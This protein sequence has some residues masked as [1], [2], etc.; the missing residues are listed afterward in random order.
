MKIIKNILKLIPFLIITLINIGLLMDDMKI[1]LIC[2][3]LW[4]V[5]L[6]IPVILSMI[7]FIGSIHCSNAWERTIVIW[8]ILNTVLFAWCLFADNTDKNCT[9]NTMAIHY[10]TYYTN[11]KDL[12]NYV[13][14]AIDD[15][16]SIDLEFDGRS[17]GIFH[18][19][20]AS[21]VYKNHWDEEAE[22][23]KD[24]LMTIVGLSEEEY[25]N[26]RKQLKD[27]DCLGI[28]FSQLSS[29]RMTIYFCREGMGLYSYNIYSRP[30]TEKEK[31]NAIED[32]ALIPYNEYCIFEYGGG[33]IGPQIFA[34]KEREEFMKRNNNM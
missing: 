31:C 21:G 14:T 17:A 15:S 30:L 27:M 13:K 2:I 1:F 9:P 20:D 23:L 5:V 18:V 28:K 33:A 24:S 6:L 11:M 22:L 26:I 12:H 19:S 16:C 8:G 29:D 10:E 4:W 34:T 25:T 3:F 7:F 32:L